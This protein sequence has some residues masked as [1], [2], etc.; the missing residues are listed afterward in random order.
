M[1]YEIPKLYKPWRQTAGPAVVDLPCVTRNKTTL[2]SF[3]ERLKGGG[4]AER[5]REE[6][7]W[8]EGASRRFLAFVC[9][10]YVS[11]NLFLSYHCPPPTSCVRAPFF[12]ACAGALPFR[13]GIRTFVVTE[14]SRSR[15]SLELTYDGE[16]KAALAIV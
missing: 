6:S 5:E 13:R 16:G 15:N 4:G 11:F 1:L 9:G 3:V 14:T 2:F 7:E 10:F 12:L 8:S